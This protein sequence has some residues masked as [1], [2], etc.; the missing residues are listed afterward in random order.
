LLE[1]KGKVI[2]GLGEGARYVRM[3]H[4]NIILAELLGHPPYPGTLNLV[5]NTDLSSI[6]DSCPPLSIKSVSIEGKSFGGFYY[7]RGYL[8][9]G[10]GVVKV[11]LLR[12]YYTKHPPNVIEAIAPQNI[13]KLLNL[14]DNDEVILGMYCGGKGT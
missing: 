7:W 5:L 14:N 11:I 13:R 10:D 1:I 3:P 9:K 4:Y 2:S 6:I 8:K 12:P